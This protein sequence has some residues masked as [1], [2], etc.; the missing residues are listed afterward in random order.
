[1]II[2]VKFNKEIFKIKKLIKIKDFMLK[3]LIRIKQES[4]FM[5]YFLNAEN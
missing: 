5:N 1:M 3:V 4:S 2:K